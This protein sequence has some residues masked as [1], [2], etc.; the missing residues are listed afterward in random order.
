MYRSLI[1]CLFKEFGVVEHVKVNEKT[2]S[3]HVGFRDAESVQEILREMPDTI[4][5]LAALYQSA[6]YSAFKSTFLV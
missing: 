2:R 6:D 5:D 3:A 1:Q 4:I